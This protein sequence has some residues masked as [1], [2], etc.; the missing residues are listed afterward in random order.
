MS[1]KYDI[2]FGRYLRYDEESPSG[3]VWKPRRVDDFKS[4]QAYEAF[5]TK[6]LNKTAGGISIDRHGYK[7][8]RVKLFN[9]VCISSRVIYII[10]VGPID[11]G[12]EID[13]IDGDSLNNK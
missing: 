9:Q 7:L 8:W 5:H 1:D 10:M 4:M 3:L 2:D 11:K 13:H 12:L 6:H